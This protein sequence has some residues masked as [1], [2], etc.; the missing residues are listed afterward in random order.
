MNKM[1]KRN[2]YYN[3]SCVLQHPVALCRSDIWFHFFCL[4]AASYEVHSSYLCYEHALQVLLK[5]DNSAETYS[6]C[7]K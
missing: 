3:T 5:M 2:C 6:L 1:Q 4:P 7:V